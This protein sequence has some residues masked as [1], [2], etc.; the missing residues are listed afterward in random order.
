MRVS[1]G[2]TRLAV[3]A[4]AA[5][6]LVAPLLASSSASAA[7]SSS[8]SLLPAGRTLACLAAPGKTAKANATI[9]SSG[10]NQTMTLKVSGIRPNLDVDLFTVEKSP[11]TAAGTPDPAFDGRFGLAWYQSDLHVGD[12]GT[13]QVTIKTI[14]N[15]EIFGFDANTGLPPTHTFHVGFWFNNPADAAACGF[16]GATPFNGEQH[17]GPV[18]MITKPG[19]DGSGPLG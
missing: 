13:G 1:T 8:F 12:T 10:Q 3:A 4:T 19:A 6:A 18:A 5:A 7:S 2:R 14:L 16:T 11:F 9:T 17:A 15:P